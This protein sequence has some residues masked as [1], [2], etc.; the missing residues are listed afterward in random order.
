MRDGHPLEVA[1]G[2]EVYSTNFDGVGG[3]LKTRFE[4]FIVEEIK[5]TG[6]I[7]RT[8][9]WSSSNAK[10]HVEGERDRYISFTLQKMGLSTFDVSR[11]LGSALKIPSNFIT[12]AGLKDKRAI[13]AQAMSI[14]SRFYDALKSLNL[15]NIALR[16]LKYSHHPVRI[17]DLWGNRFQILLRG[18]NVDCEEAVEKI[19]PINTTPLLNYFGIQ[20]FGVVRPNTYLVGLSLVK[21][22]YEEAIHYLLTTTSEYES[23]ELTEVRQKLANDLTPTEKIIDLFPKDLRYEKSV[24]KYLIKH[25]ND[26]KGAISKIPPRVLTIFVHSFQSYIFNRLI[27]LRAKKGLPIQ[28]PIPGDFII[29]LDETHSGRDSW[30]FVTEAKLEER[31]E[32]VKKGEYALASPIPG[33]A[34]KIP[35]SRQSELLS[36]ILNDENVNLRDFRNAENRYL[37]SPGGLHLVSININNPRTECTKEGLRFSFSLRKGSYATIV[38]REI[39]K[40]NPINRV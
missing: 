40:N 39:M 28:E 6:E 26:Y 24:M 32:Q 12:Y 10:H 27:S 2:M 3:K 15:S 5:P 18:L 31:L 14:P 19:N 9:E 1:V 38:M 23:Q 25:E 37:D 29:Q 8:Q 11:I 22:K 36:K 17:G 16:D 4:D 13:T 21:R 20:R 33:Y 34:T 30:L 7:L 35:E